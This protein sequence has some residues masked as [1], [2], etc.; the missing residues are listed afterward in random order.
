MVTINIFG[1]VRYEYKILIFGTS[2]KNCSRY[3]LF[4]EIKIT[5]N[6]LTFYSH[7]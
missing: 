5:H 7:V 4:T 2:L 3:Y 6:F 1:K